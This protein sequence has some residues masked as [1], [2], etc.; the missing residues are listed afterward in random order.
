MVLDYSS[1]KFAIG[2]NGMRRSAPYRRQKE[3]LNYDDLVHYDTVV[4]R[5][6]F[7]AGNHNYTGFADSNRSSDTFNDE[8]Y[9][10]L[11]A[12]AGSYRTPR[13]ILDTQIEKEQE[14][15]QKIRH[16]DVEIRRRLR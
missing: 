5:N 7:L 11:M 16:S 6:F 3:W 10:A 12:A 8:L 14:Y 9:H 15:F 13:L 1:A 4:V 2:S